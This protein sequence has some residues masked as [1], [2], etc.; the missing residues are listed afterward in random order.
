MLQDL[1]DTLKNHR[2]FGI[3]ILVALG[4]IFAM[5][6]A[7]GV[8]DLSF[9]TPNY[10]VKVNGEEVPLATVQQAWQ[11]RQS[12]YQ[13]QIN[14]EIPF[15]QRTS[16]QKALMDEYIEATLLRQRAQQRGFRVDN[17]A[18]VAAYHAEPAFQIDGKFSQEAARGALLQAGL[19][20]AAYEQQLRQSL[21]TG[22]LTQG[23]QATDFM[24]PAAINRIIALE[25]EQRELRFAL[26]PRARYES[27]VKVDDAAILAW[28]QANASEYQTP[29]SVRL[30]YAEL[31]LEPLAAT[32]LVD[33]NEL[34]AWYEANK[35]LYVEPEKRRAR[36]ILI[37]V[38]DGADAATSAA[39]LKK[40]QS[41]LAEARS[42][43]DFAALARQYSDDTGS[44]SNGGDLG[45]ALRS[46][47]VKDFADALFGMQVGQISE[48]VKTQF[49]YHIIRLDA[50]QAS[51]GKTLADSRAQ[52]EADYRRE[53]AADLF[54]ERQ[55]QLQQRMETSTSTDLDAL[56]SEFGLQRGEVAEYTRSGASSLGSSPELTAAVFSAE[57]LSGAR[58][59]GPV[60][61]ADDRLIVF[62]VT[63]HREPRARP[64]A[65]VRDDVITAIRKSE[66][67]KAAHAAAE[68]AAGQLAGGANFDTVIRQL[69]TTAA[70][71]AYVGRGDPQLPV[72]VRDAAFKTA[73]A[74]GKP[75]YRAL[76]LEDGSA[77]LLMVSDVRP[78]KSGA[79]PAADQQLVSQYLQRQREADLAAYLQE[80]QRRASVKRN[81]AAFN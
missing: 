16:M 29:E 50:I 3:L 26:L 38:A 60:A 72:E 47:Y 76:A 35:T 69:G 34:Q 59:G 63:E 73:M 10:A 55:E 48:P 45:W 70:P 51:V 9:G 14:G 61:L 36:H 71:A 44:K 12:E 2:W 8:V 65:E 19:T 32:V 24:T 40:A 1:G 15:E 43:K 41:V 33:Q 74:G 5:W 31:R 30:Q 57:A 39:A 58:L 4:L 27:A 22:Q 28:Y 68:A 13:Q 6:G 18:V 75:A 56:A 64:L 7:Y 23:L 54:G 46:A 77:A 81:P 78:G 67:A 25:N 21:Q 17:D 37:Q 66:G 79:N 80:M 11:R 53:R 62:K 42:G 49:G 52:I 20:A